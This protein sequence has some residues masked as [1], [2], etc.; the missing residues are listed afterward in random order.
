MKKIIISL[1]VVAAFAFGAKAQT[2]A[3]GFIAACPDMPSEQ[4][5]ISYIVGNGDNPY[6]AFF[7]GLDEV[8]ENL[9]K[10]Q[11]NIGSS[12]THRMDSE[13][14]KQKVTGTNVTLEEAEKMSKAERK[15]LA[16]ASTASQ[17]AAM[18]I[19]M[20]DIQAL[21]SGKMSEEEMI[22]K[23]MA[24]QSGGLNMK[25]IEAMQNMT[26]EQRVAFMMESGLAD[27][28]NANQKAN[29]G[30]VNKNASLATVLMKIGE[31]QGRLAELQQRC[32]NMRIEANQFGYE[33]YEKSYKKKVDALEES[34]IEI[35]EKI[36]DGEQ[37]AAEAAKNRSYDAQLNALIKQQAEI[38]KEFWGKAIPV[39]RNAV[40][41][42]QNLIK[43]EMLTLQTETGR[44]YDEA[45]R[46]SKDPQY[47]GGESQPILAVTFYLDGAS[48]IDKYNFGE[49]H[50][51][52]TF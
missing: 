5:M 47:L 42:S 12:L 11:M 7:A 28:M 8:R 44:L 31:N 49:V 26:E 6:D 23:M 50:P 10:Y 35:E 52:R 40:V 13:M 4:Q 9:E 3:E 27:Q 25:D 38:L 19:S 22:N 46:I 24:K 29:Q 2:S 39:W 51:I 30:K 33:L 45:Y 20:K 41:K 37:T 15:A 18:G 17:M 16:Q 34:I 36:Y 14:K 21:E 43:S 32:I 1:T 48:E